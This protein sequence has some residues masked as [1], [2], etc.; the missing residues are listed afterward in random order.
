MKCAVDTGALLSLACSAHFSFI[1]EEHDL[2]TTEEVHDELLEFA[3]YN[4]FL[5][6][7][8]Q[9][10]LKYVDE[11]KITKEKPTV[12]L[13]LKIAAA[14]LSVF[15]LGKEKKY[16]IL[17]DDLHAARVAEQQLRVFSRPSFFLFLHLYKSKKITRQ[18]LLVDME[19]VVQQRKWMSGVLYKYVKEVLE[20]LKQK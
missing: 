4:D 1:L 11:K 2:I 20:S 5:G 10:I 3:A 13:S 18:E 6:K 19:T 14:E 12:F 7:Q 16:I 9:K 8:A 15:S 17:T